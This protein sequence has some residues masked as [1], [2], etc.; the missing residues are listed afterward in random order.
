MQ[1]QWQRHGMSDR[2]L[3]VLA[4]YW[5]AL[6]QGQPFPARAQID[7]RGFGAAIDRVFLA[8]P[9]TGAEEVAA[10]GAAS[11]RLRVVGQRL[12]ALF[13][14]DLGG[15]PLRALLSEDPALPDPD[16]R[17][18]TGPR[19]GDRLAACLAALDAGQ[20]VLVLLRP[21]GGRIAG[22]S[23]GGA[24]PD[25]PCLLLPLADRAGKPAHVIGALG[26]DAWPAL[27]VL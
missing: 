4:A 19:P 16:P 22:L 1:G 10:S 12:N 2:A 14:R 3:A 15:Q 21:L 13:G 17:P 27:A 24:L 18:G 7:P 8:A 11:A 20:P 26:L 23:G 25:L 9:P 5:I 6:R